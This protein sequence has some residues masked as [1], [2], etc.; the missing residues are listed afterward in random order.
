ML[1]DT[2][3]I[4]TDGQ[5]P[6]WVYF[7]KACTALGIDDVEMLGY[8]EFVQGRLNIFAEC[9]RSLFPDREPWSEDG[10]WTIS[11]EDLR[12]LKYGPDDSV[13]VNGV[14]GVITYRKGYLKTL[15]IRKETFEEIKSISSAQSSTKPLTE[16]ERGKMLAIILGMAIDAYGYDPNKERNKATGENAGS[17]HAAVTKLGLSVDADTIRKYLGE[18]VALYPEAKTR[19]S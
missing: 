4:N 18:A 10:N 8:I 6:F 9:V 11:I 1:K 7:D 3:P 16:T 13:T 15:S 2:K 14:G 17:V 5:T 19:K 12:K